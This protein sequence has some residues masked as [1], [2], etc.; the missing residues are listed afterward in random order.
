MSP[1]KF[2]TK[3]AQSSNLR[4][5]TP[6]PPLFIVLRSLQS[7][8]SYRISNTTSIRV[9]MTAHGFEGRHN[10]WNEAKA[11][12]AHWFV[13]GRASHTFYTINSQMALMLLNLPPT[14]LLHSWRFL[15]LI[16]I[17]FKVDS[18]AIMRLEGLGQSKKLRNL[19]ENRSRDLRA[20]AYCF[21]KLLSG[22]PKW[23][24]FSKFAW[25]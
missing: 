12:E 23:D 6:P 15:V 16:S 3:S 18:K 21:N 13:I 25:I 10:D 22:L 11:F 7:G 24:V 20:V 5:K 1:A 19:I 14:F 17:K 2:C 8:R 9:C 4:C